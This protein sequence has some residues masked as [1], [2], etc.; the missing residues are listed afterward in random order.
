MSPF[1]VGI[2]LVLIAV[3]AG[4]VWLLYRRDR[5]RTA[6]LIAMTG[7]ERELLETTKDHDLDV[8]QAEATLRGVTKDWDK[9]VQNAENAEKAQREV[10]STRTG[11]LGS[12]GSLHL[13]ED[14]LEAPAGIVFFAAGP[15]EA[16]VDTAANLA[17]TKQGAIARL[18]AEGVEEGPIFEERQRHEA[19]ELFLLLETPMFGSLTESRPEDGAKVRRFAMSINAA[20]QVWANLDQLRDQVVAAVGESLEEV[21]VG[22]KEQIAEAEQH[23]AVVRQDTARLDAARLAVEQPSPKAPA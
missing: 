1:L 18:L 14:R 11:P 19:R 22:Q 9:R 17:V 20:S 21:Y 3:V 23:L 16:T 12:F 13:F 2:V 10:Q 4:V 5:K 15:V 8:T 7:E 6:R